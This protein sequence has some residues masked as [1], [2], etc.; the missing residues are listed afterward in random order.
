MVAPEEIF[1]NF[2]AK[3]H[4]FRPISRP[5]GKNIIF[6]KKL[7]LSLAA[8]ATVALGASAE[9][10]QV[11]SLS[12]K[13][14]G[15]G[16][17]GT[18]LKLGAESMFFNPGALTFMDKTFEVSGSI[19]ATA[20]HARA[21]IDGK[22]YTT[23]SKISTPLN[24]AAAFRIYDNLYGGLMFYT[25]YGSSINWTKNWP[26]AVLNQ[27]VD[28]KVYAVQPTMSWRLTPNFSIGA[29]IVVA[30]GSVNLNKGL[31]D[32]GQL[33]QLMQLNAAG[34]KLK[35]LLM[36]EQLPEQFPVFGNVSPASAHLTGNS[37]VAVGFN[38]GAFY[39]INAKWSVG[40]TFRSK[41]D[42]HVKAGVVEVDYANEFAEQILQAELNNLNSTN[43]DASMPCPWVLAAGVS[44]KPIEKLTL[45]FDAQLN[46]W[47]TYKSLDI[48]FAEQS[49]F[50]QHLVKDYKNATTWHLGGQ[51][52][53][54]P[55]LDL[56]AGLMVD[57]TPCN[58]QHYNPET[59][60]TT[61]ILP[62]AGLSFR[63]IKGLSI[64][65][66]FNYLTGLKVK[67]AKGEYDNFLAAK[68]DEGLATYNATLATPVAPGVTVGQYLA[69]QGI[70]MPQ[71]Q[72]MQKKCTIIGDYKIHAFIPSIGFSYSF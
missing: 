43:F 72:P 9:G 32:A 57:F 26:A 23:D 25:P 52:A 64:D 8:M 55:R 38:V 28:L 51:Y 22:D 30:W 40:L 46:G 20:S 18:A 63:P 71:F 66:A 56:R 2:V 10:Y 67:G 65:F 34:N 31:V 4:T 70:E 14:N 47:K 53:V 13:Q 16:H 15:M 27:S 37:Q 61:R 58:K 39:D 19:T 6:M 17:T 3:F 68:Y 54:T 1:T 69:A 45:A 11:N 50:D 59:P 29:G 5:F 33:D 42:M 41:M 24:I 21:T 44:F 49:Q 35:N 62:G 48:A 12:A 7:L 36:G 60:G